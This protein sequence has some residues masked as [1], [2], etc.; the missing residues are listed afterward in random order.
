MSLRVAIGVVMVALVA[1]IAPARAVPVTL[2]DENFDDVTGLTSTGTVRSVTAILGSTPGELPSGAAGPGTSVN[3]RRTDNTIDNT[4]GNNGFDNFFTGTGAGSNFLVLGDNAGAL[5][6]AINVGTVNFSVL[7][8]LPANTAS[9]TVSYDFVFD[10]NDGTPAT[11]SPDDFIVQFLDLV[12]ADTVAVQSIDS[13]SQNGSTRG[14][15]STTL[16]ALDFVPL[17]A[18]FRLNFRLTEFS[19]NGSSAV[20]LDNLRV[21]ADVREPDPPTGIPA[22][23]T[24]PIL[25]AGLALAVGLRRR[26]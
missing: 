2:V 26:G 7:V 24:L 10:T 18:S 16:S 4:V 25:A 5:A 14:S 21:V 11:P 20:G 9:V 1:G 8:T 19:G 13:P 22:P 17:G 6:N 3:V 12:D 23:A 15:F